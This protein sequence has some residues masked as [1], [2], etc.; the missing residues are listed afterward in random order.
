MKKQKILNFYNVFIEN[1]ILKD[2]EVLQLIIPNPDTGLK[3][4]TIPTAMAIISAMDL[5]GLLLNVKGKTNDSSDNIAYFVNFN[6]HSLFPNYYGTNE[7]DKICNY[8]SGMMHHFFPK[9]KG[10]FAGICK[11]GKNPSLFI[12]HLAIG[13]TEES[14]NVTVL[15][16]D[17]TEAL[18]KLKMYL[19]S[20]TDE[21]LFETILMHLKNLD[22]YLDIAPTNT[23]C[24]TISPG[25][26]KNP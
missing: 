16:K 19:E 3:G 10:Q 11:D 4:C 8:R 9:F 18:K 5:L 17:F 22:Y 1:F 26:P 20:S 12:S 24:T 15:A 6:N 7:I 23:K 14:L 25:T 21:T 2:L 13:Q